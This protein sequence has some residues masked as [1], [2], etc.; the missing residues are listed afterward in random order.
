MV[1]SDHRVLVCFQAFT[2]AVALQTL[3][4]RDMTLTSV[5]STAFSG[6]TSL[7]SLDLSGNRLSS[8]PNAVFSGL[9]ALTEL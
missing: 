8:L 2:G 6:L 4:L 5:D 3:I 7:T 9:T 1:C